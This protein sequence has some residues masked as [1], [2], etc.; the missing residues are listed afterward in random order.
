MFAGD[1]MK[2]YQKN[3]IDLL[4]QEL[5]VLIYAGDKDFICNWLGNQ[6]WTDRLEWSGSKGFSKAPVRSWKVN[7]KEAGEVKNYKH[8]TFLRVFGG[9][10]MVPYDQPENSLDMVNRWV[11]GDYKY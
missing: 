8:F 11:S 7:G 9:G 2:P 1:W 6:A 4:E 5:P 3:V 10:H